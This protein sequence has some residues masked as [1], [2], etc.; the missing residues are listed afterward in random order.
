MDI[1]DINN[2]VSSNMTYDEKLEGIEQY[3]KP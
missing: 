1:L 2:V 3:I